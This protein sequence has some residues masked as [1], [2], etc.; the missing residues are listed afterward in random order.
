MR[1]GEEANGYTR[2][3]HEHDVCPDQLLTGYASTNDD[4]Q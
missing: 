4:F 2:D 3:L 1:S